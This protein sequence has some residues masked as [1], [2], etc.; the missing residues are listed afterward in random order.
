M[1]HVSKE[2]ILEKSLGS[3]VEKNQPI[4]HHMN[5]NINSQKKYISSA[6]TG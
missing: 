2:A 4:L 5:M 3:S 6:L 1:L